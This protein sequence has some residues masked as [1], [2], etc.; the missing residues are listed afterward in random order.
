MRIGA[1]RA[2]LAEGGQ[3]WPVDAPDD[4]TVGGVVATAPSSPRRPPVRTAPRLG[5]RGRARHRRRAARPERRA[6]REE[7]Q[8]Y[9]VHRLATGS[10]GTLGAI[11]QVAVKVRPLPRRGGSWSRRG[12]IGA[13]R[14]CSMR[15]RSPRRS[16]RRPTAWRSGSRDGPRRSRS[17][18]RRSERV[19]DV[20]DGAKARSPAPRRSTRRS[21]SRWRS[22]PRSS[23]AVL[24][25]EPN[26]PRAARRRD[27][28]VGLPD[29]GERLDIAPEA[30]R[31]GR[32]HRAGDP[33][34][35]RPRRRAGRRAG[36]PPAPQG[37]VRPREHPR[38][39]PLLGRPVGFRRC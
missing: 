33:W 6:H 38:P 3:E 12:G 14:G 1:L 29:D 20:A 7:R 24:D 31:R 39:R 28:W 11:V 9:D 27:R 8:G 36:R 23:N 19:A 17:R 10:L 22:R 25:G 37:R 4:A 30:R 15:S 18:P 26:V 34:S 35:R 32:R 16:S 2:V 13:G 5:R 21:S